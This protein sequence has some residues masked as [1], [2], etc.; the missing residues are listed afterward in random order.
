MQYYTHIH[1]SKLKSNFM[2]VIPT[3]A[4]T[5]D[6]GLCVVQ[7]D[8]CD[9]EDARVESQLSVVSFI[10]KKNLGI[11]DMHLVLTNMRVS[12]PIHHHHLMLPHGVYEVGQ[13]VD[14]IFTF[15]HPLDLD[16][17]FIHPAVRITVVEHN[18][19]HCTCHDHVGHLLPLLEASVETN[20]VTDLNHRRQQKEGE[21]V[22]EEEHASETPRILAVSLP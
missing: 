16:L 20:R 13:L 12:K 9:R 17:A 14:N 1:K 10:Q 18:F 3:E 4:P 7:V 11:C 21:E 2:R 22:N 8:H 19:F 5:F 15:Q 6:D